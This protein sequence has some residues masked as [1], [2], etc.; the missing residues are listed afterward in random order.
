MI[1]FQVTTVS[2]RQMN[3]WTLARQM[4]LA[5][6][7]IDAV[8][9]IERLAGMQAQHSPSPYIGL[10]SRLTDFRREELETALVEDRVYKASLMRVTLHLVSARELHFYSVAARA[11][12]HIYAQMMSQFEEHG[13]DAV[14]VKHH[15]ERI[16]GDAPGGEDVERGDVQSHRF[17]L[18]R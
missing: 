13:V 17:A 16:A 6:A 12:A 2:L 10:W 4:L 5:R 9:A 8:T 18:A 11:P 3:R 14:G 1:Q 15:A 7:D